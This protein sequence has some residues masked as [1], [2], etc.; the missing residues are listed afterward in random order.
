ML[1]YLRTINIKGLILDLRNNAGGFVEPCLEIASQLVPKGTLVEL[2]RK[3]LKE[4]LESETEPESIIPV[5]VLVNGGTAS[6]SEILAG[7]IRDR[8]VGILIG[9]T[10]FGKA[11]VQT[12][13]PLANGTGLRLTIADY[14]TPSGYNLA[15]RG[16]DPD[17]RVVQEELTPPGPITYKRPMSLGHVGLDVLAMQESLKLLGYQV[18]EPDGIF[19]PQTASAV[20]AFLS[21]QHLKWNGA[22]GEADVER[23]GALVWQKVR[24][25]PDNVLEVAISALRSKVTSGSWE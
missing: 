17:I 6:A 8:G 19:G 10:T 7:A 22:F 5:A 9:D 13:V 14:Y 25:V 11:S 20:Q 12:L 16:L 21:D 1:G 4:P 23:L 3:E 15:G 24:S 2:R 18:G